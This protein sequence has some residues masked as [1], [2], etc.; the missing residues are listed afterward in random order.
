MMDRL[1]EIKSGIPG[2]KMDDSTIAGSWEEFEYNL[3]ETISSTPMLPNSSTSEEADRVFDAFVNQCE[4]A[5]ASKNKHASIQS[6]VRD[7]I[8][9]TPT[10][11][12]F[13]AIFGEQET[14]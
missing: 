10:A 11:D 9:V 14:A 4:I 12:M 6:D 8:S 13:E 7:D 1:D 3:R 2:E 5:A